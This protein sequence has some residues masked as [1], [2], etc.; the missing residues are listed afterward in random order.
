LTADS[1]SP[2]LPIQFATAKLSAIFAENCANW[3]ANLY[4]TEEDITRLLPAYVSRIRSAS[5]ALIRKP[6]E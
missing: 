6:F 2:V 4:G 1:H 3:H 5:T